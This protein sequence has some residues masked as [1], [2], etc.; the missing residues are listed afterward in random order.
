M[1]VIKLIPLRWWILFSW[2]S[3]IWKCLHW[4]Q[5]D[6]GSKA[7]SPNNPR[8]R[9]SPLRQVHQTACLPIQENKTVHRRLFWDQQGKYQ[10]EEVNLYS[11]GREGGCHWRRRYLIF[12]CKQVT[13]DI[14]SLW[15]DTPQLYEKK[16]GLKFWTEN[17]KKVDIIEMCVRYDNNSLGRRLGCVL[18]SNNI[19][20][21]Q[22]SGKKRLNISPTSPRSLASSTDS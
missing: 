20:H 2:W 15:Q 4:L 9:L 7:D 19:A 22:T 13:G 8:L 6:S 11:P 3:T 18:K 10:R 14:T 5:C 1:Y 12:L 21:W 16:Y 17:I